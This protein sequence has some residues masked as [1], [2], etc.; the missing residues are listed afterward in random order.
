MQVEQLLSSVPRVGHKAIYDMAKMA[1]NLKELKPVPPTR[2]ASLSPYVNDS[3]TLQ[4]LLELGVDLS[5]VE[6]V[7]EVARHLAL[8]NFDRDCKPYI[9][10]CHSLGVKPQD[11]GNMLSN[12]PNLFLESVENLEVRMNYFLSKKFKKEDIA[13]IVMRQPKILG[14]KVDQIDSQLGYLQKQF[15]LT[16]NE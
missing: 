6:T 1:V 15:K 4:T 8:A 7:P 13:S 9:L 3:E 2:S 11:I 16:G 10:F 5:R 14:L 12:F